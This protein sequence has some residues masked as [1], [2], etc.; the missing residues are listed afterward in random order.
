[1]LIIIPFIIFQSCNKEPDNNLQSKLTITKN[2]KLHPVKKAYYDENKNRYESDVFTK[3]KEEFNYKISVEKGEKYRV[4]VYGF[5]MENV[6]LFLYDKNDIV[7]TGV[8]ANPEY[9]AKY[10]TFI[11]DNTDSLIIQLKATNS[12]IYSMD[13]Y[14]CFEQLNAYKLYWKGHTWLCDGDWEVNSNNQLE[15]KGNKSGF[16]KWIK[17]DDTE[18]IDYKVEVDVNIENGFINNFVGIA[19]TASNEIFNM[20]NLPEICEQFKINNQNSWENW[21]I[22]VGN[23]GGG[24]GRD[25]GELTGNFNIGSNIIKAEIQPNSLYFY[26]NNELA[27]KT[28]RNFRHKKQFYFTCED[29]DENTIKVNNIEFNLNFD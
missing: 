15:F 18:L 1:M 5:Y 17:L 29:F 28:F 12:N 23:G 22:N 21:I 25:F 7:Q 26:L 16:S 8:Q 24:I 13:F 14:L 6:D 27:V 19:V 3:E 2:L 10:F 20:I 4:L 11:A 9:T